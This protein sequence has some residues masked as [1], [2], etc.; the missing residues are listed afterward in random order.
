MKKI[1]FPGLFIYLILSIPISLFSQQDKVTIEGKLA[2]SN[3]TKI[4]FRN[5]QN[6]QQVVVPGVDSNGVFKAEF[7]LVAASFF[8]LE[9]D[10]KRQ[11]ILAFEPG[12]KVSIY[13]DA[14]DM[15]G[16]KIE[17]SKQSKFIISTFKELHDFDVKA[18]EYKKQME[19]EKRNHLK[20]KLLTNK[21]E[22]ATLAFLENFSL[23]EDK[24][25]YENISTS[26]SQNYPK[27]KFVMDLNQKVHQE[28][29]LPLGSE[30]PN[31]KLPSPEGK[32]IQLSSLRGKVVLIDFWASWCGP[33]RRENPHVV[34]IYQEYKDKGFEIFGVSL[35]KNKEGWLKAIESDNLNWVHVS[36][37]KQWA[38]PVVPLYGV[39]GIPYTVLLDR[40]GVVLAK[41]LRG[42]AL[43]NK[44]KEV[45]GE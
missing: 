19:I 16:A 2:N 12:D 17:G 8:R 3:L 38:S 15:Y 44:L 31:I 20:Q 10:E 4:T 1:N 13:L 24:E 6:S 27:N 39:K 35:D 30:A 22:L 23:K 43:E 5:L 18:E 25:L 11:L 33:C 42:N 29:L 28:N 41:G 36:D 7:P 14:Q 37:L 40:E 21:S 9:L 32:E 26:L 45:L 34:K